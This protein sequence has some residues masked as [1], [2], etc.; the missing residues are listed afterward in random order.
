MD[1][2]QYRNGEMFAEEVPLATIAAEVGT[3]VYVYSAATLRRHA[4]VMQ[5]ALAP[6]GDPLIAFAVK[7]NSNLAI[8]KLLGQQGLGA[9][10]VSEGE[11]R[12]ALAAGIPANRIVFSGVGK[13]DGEM[14]AALAAGI[15]QLNVESESELL[16]LSEVASRMGKTAEIAF[17]VNPDVDAQ[18]HEKISTGKAENKFGIP[19]SRIEALYAR[20]QELPG[21][22]AVGVTAHIGSQLFDLAP[23]E[24]A[25]AKLGALVARLRQAG[26]AVSRVDLGGGLGIPYDPAQPHPPT[27]AEYGAMVQRTVAAWP[28]SEGI[29]L[30][31]EPGRLIAGNAGLLLAQVVV[32]KSGAAQEFVVLDAAMNDLVRPTLY[33]AYH[34]IRAV[35]PRPGEMTATVVGPVCETGDQFAQGRSI[36]PVEEGDLLALMTAG[37]YGAVMSNTYNSRAL[38]PE[39]L[40]DGDR[41]AVIR[42]RQTLDEQLALDRI[43]EWI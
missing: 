19:L 2:F 34:D 23:L 30:M 20:A 9:D 29:R 33:S 36:P 31:F 7:A 24:Q 43:P 22:R 41:Y 1:H 5:Q 11:M 3:P 6:L 32:R 8:L 27:P 42:P 18:T 37:A 40:V 39:V 21:I 13:T 17:R 10:V 28:D 4:T 14:R 35:R 12:R 26:H 38:V 15:L 25:F 16:R